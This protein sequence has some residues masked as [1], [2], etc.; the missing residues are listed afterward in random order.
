METFA[1]VFKNLRK[2]LGF[3]FTFLPSSKTLNYIQWK[4]NS[5]APNT[6]EIVRL[7]TNLQ[8]WRPGEIT[9]GTD[10]SIDVI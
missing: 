5:M 2:G 10:I 3:R 4:T 1:C 7:K 8:I 9:S 6:E